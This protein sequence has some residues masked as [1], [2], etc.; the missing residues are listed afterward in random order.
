MQQFASPV[1]TRGNVCVRWSL[2]QQKHHQISV[3][4]CFCMNAACVSYWTLT[5]VTLPTLS[6]YLLR[7]CIYVCAL[8]GGDACCVLKCA[9][10][11]VPPWLILKAPFQGGQKSDYWNKARS[12]FL[13]LPHSASIYTQLC[14][15]VLTWVNWYCHCECVCASLTEGR[16]YVV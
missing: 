8:G 14:L 4:W 5:L 9:C 10:S 1:S 13:R 11:A 7:V 16:G 3:C 6:S 2:K 12:V 15:C